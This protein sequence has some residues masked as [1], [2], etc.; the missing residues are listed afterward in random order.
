MIPIPVSAMETKDYKTPAL[1]KEQSKDTLK[2]DVMEVTFEVRNF[3]NL[4]TK[5]LCVKI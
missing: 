4:A 3:Y 1:Y 5:I 2:K